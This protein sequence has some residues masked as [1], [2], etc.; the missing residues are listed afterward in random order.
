LLVPSA[1]RALSETSSC[2]PKIVLL[3]T[4]RWGDGKFQKPPIQW[5]LSQLIQ[6]ILEKSK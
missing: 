4:Q 6:Q 3:S 1:L 5:G 2:L